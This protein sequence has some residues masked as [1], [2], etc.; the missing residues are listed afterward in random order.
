VR[1]ALKSGT[2]DDQSTDMRFGP[3]C[4]F[5]G[6]GCIHFNFTD[7]E[8]E[9]G[10]TDPMFDQKLVST[11][12]YAD[13]AGSKFR[14]A[15]EFSLSLLVSRWKGPTD[16]VSLTGQAT[17]RFGGQQFSGNLT[18]LPPDLTNIDAVGVAL[19]SKNKMERV[20]VRLKRFQMQV[21]P[22]K[23]P[24]QGVTAVVSK[25]PGIP[26]GALTTVP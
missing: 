15:T 6:G 14:P 20:N 16:A 3:S 18:G 2:A 17:L 24:L 22:R 4:Q 1:I 11:A 12:S 7:F 5:F 8:R 21:M 13:Y 23:V 25:A 10:N 9:P 19:A 26:I